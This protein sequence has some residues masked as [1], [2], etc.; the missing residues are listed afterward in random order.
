MI[1]RLFIS[2]GGADGGRL[3]PEVVCF[4]DGS[5]PPKDGQCQG[6]LIL[7]RNFWSGL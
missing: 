3:T 4:I 1:C 2:L 5:E 6:P 7:E